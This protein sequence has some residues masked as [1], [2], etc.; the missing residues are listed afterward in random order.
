ML[1]SYYILHTNTSARVRVLISFSSRAI[2]LRSFLRRKCTK[3]LTCKVSYAAYLHNVYTTHSLRQTQTLTHPQ[4]YRHIDTPHWQQSYRHCERLR[5]PRNRIIKDDT[6]LYTICN[7][8]FFSIPAPVSTNRMSYSQLDRHSCTTSI[9]SSC[10]LPSARATAKPRR[11]CIRVSTFY[12][13][14]I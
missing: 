14:L 7:T 9:T 12:V 11:F 8:A 4:T 3:W 5:E 2:D 10:T 6:S 13:G 1:H